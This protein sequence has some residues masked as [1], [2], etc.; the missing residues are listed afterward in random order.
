MWC[1]EWAAR[2]IGIAWREISNY[3]INNGDTE[4]GRVAQERLGI[5]KTG[6]PV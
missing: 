4:A 1:V 6:V 3:S 5:L 2:L